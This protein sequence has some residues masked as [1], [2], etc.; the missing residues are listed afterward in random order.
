MWEVC[1]HI[2]PWSSSLLASWSKP[3]YNTHLLSTALEWI[4]QDIFQINMS[5]SELWHQPG[6][7]KRLTW[8]PPRAWTLVSNGEMHQVSCPVPT[9]LAFKS[10][11]VFVSSTSEAVHTVF[12]FLLTH[13][14]VKNLIEQEREMLSVM[15]HSTWFSPTVGQEKKPN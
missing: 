7:P 6:S 2:H 4:P 15:K 10:S 14:I 8:K 5:T 11:P 1:I 12:L 3:K 9:H 13:I